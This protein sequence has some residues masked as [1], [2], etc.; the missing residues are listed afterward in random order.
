MR[1]V[2]SLLKLAVVAA[3]VCGLGYLALVQFFGLKVE[4]AGT[5]MTPIFTFHDPE[6]HFAAIEA[7]RRETVSAVKLVAAP[8][9]PAERSAPVEASESAEAPAGAWSDFRGPNRDGVWS[10]GPIRTDWPGEGLEELWRQKIG[11]GY[12]SMVVAEGLVFTIEQRR[13]V[14]VT[15]AYDLET[16]WQVW[17]HGW[18]ALFQES[19]GGEGPR[20][21]PTW[22]DGKLYTLGAA[23][24]LRCL[25]AAD[26][27]LIWRTNI[28]EDAGAKNLTWGMA[29]SPVI[30]DGK[31][32]V[33]P[34]GANGKSVAAYD[35]ETG[36]LVWQSRSEQAGYAS[37]DVKTLAGRE[38][39][40]VFTGVNMLALDPSDGALL[41]EHPWSTSYDINSAQPIVVDDTHIWL[42][43]GYGHGATLLEILPDGDGLR[44][45]KVWEKNTMKNK[46]NS[47]VL[48]GGYVYGLDES[49]LAAIDVRTGERKWKGGRYGYGQV[50][51]AD[52]HLIV[53]TEKGDVVLVKATPD[54]HQE[55]ARFSA[56]EGKTWNVPAIADG[57]L[58][59][60]NQTEMAAYALGR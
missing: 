2:V 44:A 28:L 30:H 3:V 58:L 59:V 10:G 50:L 4:M 57:T 56:L 6:S 9:K 14:E 35:A 1:V 7:D 19:M 37:P 33:C 40:L 45:E 42:S 8:E 27:E 34:G 26:G 60:R 18:P 47:A 51:L 25:R 29:G 11:G 15:A 55:L 39:V 52:G 48:A 36:A 32:I 23:G 46:F 21:T 20:A 31:A 41:W 49:I 53:L 22:H 54:S 16:G 17:E 24:E 38:Q 13:E 5:G 12:A 43:S